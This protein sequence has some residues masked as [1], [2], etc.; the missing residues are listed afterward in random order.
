M[1]AAVLT[2]ATAANAAAPAWMEPVFGNTIVTTF[3]HGKSSKTWIDRDGTFESLRVTGKRISGKWQVKGDR[4]CLR[5]SKPI[6]I[7]ISHCERKFAGGVGSTW[8]SK[9]PV[10]EALRNKLVAGQQ[11]R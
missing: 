2:V 11:G 7:P 5:Q 6:Y 8:N 4:V 3:P 1:I 9:S 10:G